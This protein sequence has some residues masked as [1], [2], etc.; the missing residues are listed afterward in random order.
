MRLI[1]LA[2]VTLASCT[3][4]LADPTA[5]ADPITTGAADAGTTTL[6]G[7]PAPDCRMYNPVACRLDLAQASVGIDVDYPNVVFCGLQLLPTRDTFNT[8][9]Y[10][11]LAAAWQVSLGGNPSDQI[12]LTATTPQN[13]LEYPLGT[14]QLYLARVTFASRSADT[15][16]RLVANAL[17]ADVSLYAVP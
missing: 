4:P 1:A 2:A 9:A 5:P 15:I 12:V 16:A 10:A 7:W 8:A 3:S 11:T 14:Q 13:V 17:G 6:P